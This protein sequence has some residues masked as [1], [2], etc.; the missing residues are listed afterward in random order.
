[1]SDVKYTYV[2]C[3]DHCEFQQ[4][5]KVDQ[6]R[7]KDVANY[8]MIVDESFL[9]GRYPGVIIEH[10]RPHERW[11]WQGILEEIERSKEIWKEEFNYD[12]EN[13]PTEEEESETANIYGGFGEEV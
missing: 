6:N 12:Q 7:G 4:L 13:L 8:H 10:G 3:K 2:A 1:M 5:V 9:R 11:D